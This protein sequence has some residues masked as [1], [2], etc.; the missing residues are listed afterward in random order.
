VPSVNAIWAE[1][2]IIASFAGLYLILFSTVIP[3]GDGL[4]YLGHIHS[5][6]LI[7]NPNHLLMD[8]VGY[9]W[10]LLL[11]TLG[12]PITAL[13]T[14]KLLS[15]L[16]SITALLVF[17]AVLVELEVSSRPMRML[18]VLGLFFSRNFLSMAIS[19]EFFMI[20]MPLLIAAFWLGIRWIHLTYAGAS[21]TRLLVGLGIILALATAVM[22][23]NCLL[24]FSS[25]LAVTFIQRQG[26]GW[27]PGRVAWVGGAAFLVIV[28]IFGVA[29]VL[30][31]TEESL[32]AWLLSYQGQRQNPLGALYGLEQN[33]RG[34]VVGSSRLVYSL[35]HNFI[36]SGDLGAI[37]KSRLTSQPLE[38][39]PDWTLALMGGVLLLATI[40]LLG[41]LAFWVARFGIKRSVVQYG[42]VWVA[43]YLL[44]NLFWN[45]SDD[46]FWF[47]LLPVIWIWL[48]ISLGGIDEKT[49]S[50]APAI[51]KW[52]HLATAILGAYFSLLMVTNTMMVVAPVT[53]VDLK[54][55][56]DAHQHLIR[57]GD[58]EIIPG[59]DDLSA[60][61]VP[62]GEIPLF[63]RKTLMEIALK[64][65]MGRLPKMI[66]RHLLG[67]GRVI[68]PR[69]WDLD[70]VARPWDELAALGW[71]RS[72]IKGLL[73]GFRTREL[74][75]IGDVVF[76]EVQLP[77]A[78][79]P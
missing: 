52:P 39:S 13:G 7:W 75:S 34:I 1:R 63:K 23:N 44:F 35:L 37:L 79:S 43:A 78:Q 3:S 53:F 27:R 70:H 5:G 32:L 54:S 8:P 24:L 58:L 74:G 69:L 18:G 46:Q 15:G 68:I 16:A 38:F 48:I 33:L 60:W 47:Q 64:G 73:R 36:D 40:V 9:G 62:E 20:Q 55:K 2:L 14:L 11:K 28:P 50:A 65:E 17:H 67:G 41:A 59:W 10:Y 30:S 49:H 19:E 76:R 77:T 21:G 22:V 42:V 71:S 25:G 51:R 6:V 26:R 4:V 12:I 66:E 29:Y 45:N 61:L 72:K 57:A 31:G 56:R